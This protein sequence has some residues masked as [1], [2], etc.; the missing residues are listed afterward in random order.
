MA[1]GGRRNRCAVTV[2]WCSRDRAGAVPREPAARPWITV[3]LPEACTASRSVPTSTP[4]AS[5]RRAMRAAD[6]HVL[7]APV[8]RRRGACESASVPI[9]LAPVVVPLARASTATR[10]SRRHGRVGRRG[11][12]HD[13]GPARHGSGRLGQSRRAGVAHAGDRRDGSDPRQGA[14]APRAGGAD[15]R[16]VH[17]DLAARPPASRRRRRGRTPAMAGS[18]AATT[19]DAG[20]PATPRSGPSMWWRA[21]SCSWPSRPCSCS[22]HRR[23]GHLARPRCV[24]RQERVGWRQRPFRML[25]FRTMYVHA[26]ARLHREFVTRFISALSSRERQRRVDGVQAQPL[27]LASRARVACSARRASTSCRSS[28]TS[29]GATCRSS[30]RVHR[31][32]TEL[33]HYE[34]WHRRR[35]LEAKPGLTGLWQVT[36]R[37]RTTFER[38]GPAGSSPTPGRAPSGWTSKILLAT[39]GAVLS[40]KGAC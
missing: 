6:T 22:W 20:S 7:A 18:T 10:A 26:D 37:S 16:A 31:C 5:A 1:G 12:E 33:D 21:S 11:G 27:I 38:D 24:Y 19:G 35:I 9:P 40:G 39:P 30:A 25:K 13:R 3:L 34:A 23:E 36:G 15:G 14:S 17:R 28:G 29:S 32:L 4:A 8:F 2:R